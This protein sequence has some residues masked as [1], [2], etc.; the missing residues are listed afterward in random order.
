M[1][2]PDSPLST[3]SS[4]ISIVTLVY[5]VTITLKVYADAWRQD[6][7]DMLALEKRLERSLQ[8]RDLF[9]LL[10]GRISNRQETRTD[11]KANMSPL[12]QS[13]PHYRHRRNLY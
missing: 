11:S 9:E 1:S 10:K 12:L 8:Y 4:F 13:L 6:D 5:A 7:R 2:E 3:T